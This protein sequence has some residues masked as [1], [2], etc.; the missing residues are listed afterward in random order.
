MSP[1]RGL[2]ETRTSPS[3][4]HIDTLR[5]Q[6]GPRTRA[7]PPPVKDGAHPC[8]V[9]A[10]PVD[11]QPG[12]QEDP[13]LH[14]DGPVGEGGDEQLI[15]AWGR[16]GHGHTGAP[17]PDGLPLSPP[18]AA[19]T[20]AECPTGGSGDPTS[21]GCGTETLLSTNVEDMP[22]PSAVQS[23]AVKAL[24]SPAHRPSSLALC[25]PRA[26]QP[27]ASGEVP[28]HTGR[29]LVPRRM[30]GSSLGRPRRSGRPPGLGGKLSS[31]CVL[32]GA[33]QNSRFLN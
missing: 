28:S 10:V 20:V 19:C 3:Y 30:W 17:S 25:D 33:P 32:R 24:R 5:G 26:P 12:G 15:P 11:V 1:A 29:T 4:V 27:H 22:L 13:V 14:G 2:A 8:A 16:R 18:Q 31:Y 9:G 7:G 21:Q 23:R 6:K